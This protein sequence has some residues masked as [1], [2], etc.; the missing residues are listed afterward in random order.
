MRMER[1]NQSYI[2]LPSEPAGQLKVLQKILNLRGSTDMDFT[3]QTEWRQSRE[4]KT[5][6]QIWCLGDL[7]YLHKKS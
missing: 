1:V 5:L 3:S 4:K 2:G 7:I 6:R